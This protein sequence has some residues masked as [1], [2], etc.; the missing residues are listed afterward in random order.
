LAL[1]ALVATLPLSVCGWFLPAPVAAPRWAL[2]SLWTWAALIRLV[3]SDGRLS[4]G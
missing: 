1:L 3:G 4:L 2:A